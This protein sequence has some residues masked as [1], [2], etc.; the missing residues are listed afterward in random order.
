[1]RHD[2]EHETQTKHAIQ[3]DGRPE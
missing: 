1:M 2:A 3:L